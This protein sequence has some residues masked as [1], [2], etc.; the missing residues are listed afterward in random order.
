MMDAARAIALVII[1]PFLTL[2]L[3][4]SRLGHLAA[5]L[6]AIAPSCRSRYLTGIAEADFNA[7]VEGRSPTVGLRTPPT[8]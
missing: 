3:A 4:P 6:A 2:L 8:A 7:F 5:L 1:E